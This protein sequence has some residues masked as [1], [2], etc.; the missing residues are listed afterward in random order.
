VTREALEEE[1]E[2]VRQ[3]G[4]AV[5][6]EESAQGL[7]CVAAPVRDASGH[8]VCALSLSSPADRLSL[9]D[10][11]RAAPQVVASADAV[12]SALGGGGR[13]RGDIEPVEVERAHADH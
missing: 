3:D 6:D 13:P 7:R 11:T 10:A 12:S 5:D 1:L 8:V 2:R 9:A 4:Y